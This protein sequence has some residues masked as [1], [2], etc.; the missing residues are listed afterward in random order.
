MITLLNSKIWLGA[1]AAGMLA[2]AAVAPAVADESVGRPST[3][4]LERMHTKNKGCVWTQ[5]MGSY[6]YECL[7]ANFNMNAHWCHNEAMEVFCPKQQEANSA[8]PA[9]DKPAN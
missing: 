1:L 4:T 3:N 7:K 2:I 8:A 5:E 6:M 9:A